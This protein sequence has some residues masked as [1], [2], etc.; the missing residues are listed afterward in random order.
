MR[1]PRKA[2]SVISKKLLSDEYLV[3]YKTD[4]KIGEKYGFHQETIR[5]LRGYYG[6]TFC[7]KSS[8]NELLLTTEQKEILLG[9]V[10]GDAHINFQ[11]QAEISHSPKQYAY[12]N[13][14]AYKLKSVL[15]DTGLH[16]N[17]GKYRI[18]TVALDTLKEM[19]CE[20]YGDRGKQPTR[21]LLD[22]LTGLSLAVWYSDDGWLDNDSN[23]HICTHGFDEES[24]DI[25]C[26]WLE[27]KWN[28]TSTVR[29]TK[30]RTKSYKHLCFDK[31]NSIKF[32]DQIKFHMLPN[33]LYKILKS[34]RDHVVYLAGAMQYRPDGGVKWRRNLKQKLNEKGYYCI[35]PTK[36]ESSMLL[37]ADWNKNIDSNFDRFQTNMRKIIDNDLYF[38]KMSG[39]IICYYDDFLGGGTFHEIGQSY[40][41]GKKLYIINANKKP[42]NKLSWWVMGC[43]TKIFNSEKELLKELPDLTCRPAYK[44]YHI[45]KRQ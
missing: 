27:E 21:N 24:H 41:L 23:Y 3:K 22:K 6:I 2:A 1:F 13:W 10:I 20:I 31:E 12:I 44:H 15:T 35:D 26:K 43:C 40:L 42:L 7:R 39:V 25:L 9:S 32:T 18:R 45:N 16:F 8:K 11:G 37:D 17:Q 34:E 19:R 14:L 5:R 4:Q 38:V 28:I 36:E 29:T 30:K 33:M